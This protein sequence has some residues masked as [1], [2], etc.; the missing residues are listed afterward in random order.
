MSIR[1]LNNEGKTVV[2]L[3]DV[4]SYEEFDKKLKEEDER[5][6]EV[7]LDQ[8]FFAQRVDERD[9][10]FGSDPIDPEELEGLKEVTCTYQEWF[11]EFQTW[12][13]WIDDGC[14]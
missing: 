1:I 7:L 9:R 10:R 11:D 12:E 3:T 4:S 2:T 6:M 5:M 13:E 14:F 8:P